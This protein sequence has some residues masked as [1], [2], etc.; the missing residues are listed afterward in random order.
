[1]ETLDRLLDKV[2]LCAVCAAHLPLGPGPMVQM[3]REA[4]VLIVG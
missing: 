2:R 1:M 3:S 4:R